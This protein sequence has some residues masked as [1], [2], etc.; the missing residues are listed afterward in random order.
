[1]KVIRLLPVLC[2]ALV[3]S[4]K[5][6]VIYSN[7]FSGEGDNVAF[8]Y[9]TAPSATASWAVDNGS[10][11]YAPGT[12]IGAGTAAQQIT[13]SSLENTG[14]T[15]ET[16]FTLAGVATDASKFNN[17][18]STL[19]FGVFSSTTD[20]LATG[21]Y[22]LVDFNFVD[23]SAA[24][25]EGVLRILKSNGSGGYTPLGTTGLADVNSDSNILA[26]HFNTT[27]TLRLEGSYNLDGHLTLT[28]SLMNAAGTTTYGTSATATDTTPYTGDYFGYRNRIG[29]S[30][31]GPVIQFD[32]YSIETV[33]EPSAAVLL[34]GAL[35]AALVKRRRGRSVR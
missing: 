7:D 2:L 1:M 6:S 18:P 4:L 16:Q 35:A 19:G 11:K 27:Y 3:P 12:S 22:Y 14:F 28:L 8:P 21:G 30:G 26:I 29:L 33:P 15:I 25:T 31:A 17:G 13:D 20:F 9:Q 34:V 23:S 5:A 10:Y 24:A 32:N